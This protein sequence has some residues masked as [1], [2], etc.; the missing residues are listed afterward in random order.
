M[1]ATSAPSVRQADDATEIDPGDTLRGTAGPGRK[2]NET[3]RGRASRVVVAVV[4]RF[5]VVVALLTGLTGYSTALAGREWWISSALVVICA[6]SISYLARVIFGPAGMVIG[7]L[8]WAGIISWMFAPE[9]LAFVI[10]TPETLSALLENLED[11]GNVIAT[12]PAPLLPPDSVILV[13]ASIFG[14]SALLSEITLDYHGRGAALG[15]LWIALLISPSIITGQL[16]NIWIFV[17][18]AALWLVLQWFETVQQFSFGA[19]SAFAIMLA[20][21]L[22]VALFAP[23]AVPDLPNRSVGSSAV[24]SQVFG[25]GINPM[26]ELGEN[27]RRGDT[28]LALTSTT[29][30]ESAQYFKVANLREFDGQTWAPSEPLDSDPFEGPDDLTADVDVSTETTNVAIAGLDSNLLPVPYP[31]VQVTGLRGDWAWVRIGNTVQAN[32]SSTQGQTYSVEHLQPLLQVAQ[33]RSTSATISAELE[34]YYLTL[35]ADIPPVIEQTAREVT[36]G[37]T[38]DYDRIAMLQNWLRSEFEYSE[39]APV[40][41]GYDGNGLDVIER[42]LVERSGYCVHFSSTLA[43]M[44]RT[45]GM[46]SRVSVG[47]APG[48]ATGRNDS[49]QTVYSTT[50]QDLHAW[51]EVYFAGIGWVPFDPT[52]GVGEATRMDGEELPPTPDTPTP[53]PTEPAESLPTP[54]ISDEP[55]AADE[56]GNPELGTSSASWW[57][58]L[59]IGLMVLVLLAI[60][61][62]WRR[63][64]RHRRLAQA[65]TTVGPLW[66]ELEDTAVD[67]GL[68]PLTGET[69]RAFA[70][71]LHETVVETNLHELVASL[72]IQRYSNQSDSQ[73]APELG[74]LVRR[75]IKEIERSSTTV[76]RIGASLLPRS[77]LR[78]RHAERQLSR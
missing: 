4:E 55:Q 1:T 52:P 8:G 32:S 58:S 49:G 18:M 65:A 42:F 23:T 51:T 64:R 29:S 67:H 13:V 46:P 44:A 11:A 48:D 15:V 33:L 19:V 56:S 68:V 14:L 9:T 5:A 69:P 53:E 71:R 70:H 28:I 59:A 47:Y 30:A 24:S 2:L 50:S 62:S 34:P 6:V 39:T 27:L 45:M 20:G 77:L 7:L 54:E 21:A 60:P 78:W 17:V 38:N 76:Q 36:A 73:P 74:D 26:L 41:A 43:V 12:E 3:R 40:E 10:P 57:R 61:A 37:A 72:E 35:P 31:A 66:D 25:R 63:I 75:A 22:A 16:P